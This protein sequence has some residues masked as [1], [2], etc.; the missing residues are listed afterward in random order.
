MSNTTGIDRIVLP[1]GFA[2]FITSLASWLIGNV[3]NSDLE[4]AEKKNEV[5]KNPAHIESQNIGFTLFVPLG[6]AHLYSPLL[7]HALPSL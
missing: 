1:I 5:L 3:N 4:F 6:V 7:S 2:F